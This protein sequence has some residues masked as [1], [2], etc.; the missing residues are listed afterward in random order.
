[1][2]PSDGPLA[3]SQDVPTEDERLEFLRH[4]IALSEWNIRTLDTKAQ[5]SIVAFVLSLSPLWS[6]LTSTC[7]RAASSLIVAILLVLF[8]ASVLLFALVILPVAS[9]QPKPT[10]GWQEKGLFSVGDPNLIAASLYAN[11]VDSLTSE[12]QL[13]AEAL[14]FARVRETKSRRFKH[15]LRSVFV[16]YAWSV[17]AFLMLRDCGA[18]VG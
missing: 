10:G 8:V 12:V 4:A 15:A 5:I 11:R 14:N 16:F 1:M 9:A 2:A 3:M 7:P 17:A 13:A 18:A 6:I